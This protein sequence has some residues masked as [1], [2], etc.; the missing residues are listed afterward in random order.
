[1]ATMSL[2]AGAI[3]ALIQG[4]RIHGSLYHDPAIFEL[5][6]KNIWHKAW[7]F[8]GHES[9]VKKAGDYV[10]KQIGRE[11][12]LLTRC[13]D[14]KVRLLHNR[15]PHRANQ[16]CSEEKGNA[17]V[18]RCPYHG[19]TFSNDGK[20][21]GMPYSEGY[22]PDLDR[23]KL[24]MSQVAR[25]GMY[26]GFV[27]G[28]LSD[29]GP[30]LEEHLG[31]TRSLIDRVADLSPEGE[32]E[33]PGLWLKHI[34]RMNWKMPYENEGDGYH[35]HFTHQ[36]IF[37]S[38]QTPKAELFGEKNLSLIRYLGLGH[39]TLDTVPEYRKRNQRFYWFGAKDSYMPDYVKTMEQR[40]GQERAQQML[41][42]G[43]GFGTM[44]F[45]NL[46]LAE[47]AII[48]NIPVSATE[49]IQYFSPIFLKGVPEAVNIR[50]LRQFE[51]AFGPAGMIHGDDVVMY[52]RNQRGVEAR[53]PEW[54]F[55]GRG[56]HREKT[57]TDG[58][59]SSNVTDETS[60]RGFWQHY[61][62][63]MSAE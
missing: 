56:M 16:V 6:L 43:P 39:T 62:N 5:E 30:T 36:S 15:C 21:V 54:L 61:K 8:L 29:S 59:R 31:H 23:T 25:V 53:Q 41:V 28:S 49:T 13:A 1:M 51:G 24:G 12:V 58:T 55:L 46:F 34:G 33:L 22:G 48:M 37:K 27:W 9:E 52:E 35:P 10:R 45:P 57:E 2:P 40:Y 19:W 18:L 26:R 17:S 38:V 44:I 11:A 60:M 42:D 14:G 20:L 63:V 47:L 3:G 7:V 50:S 32:V 4:D